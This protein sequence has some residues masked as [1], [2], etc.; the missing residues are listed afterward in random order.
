[1]PSN[2]RDSDTAHG[3]RCVRRC[4]H[5]DGA[6]DAEAAVPARPNQRGHGTLQTLGTRRLTLARVG[7]IGHGS[8]YTRQRRRCR[9]LLV[10]FHHHSILAHRLLELLVR[11]HKLACQKRPSIRRR[12]LWWWWR[13]RHV[14]I[15]GC[16]PARQLH[17][18]V[19]IAKPPSFVINASHSAH[20]H[21]NESA[22][23]FLKV[24]RFCFN[25]R[26]EVVWVDRSYR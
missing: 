16:R 26:T 7:F 23:F 4:A 1:M 2:M 18:F 22:L 8:W 12:R 13:Q 10:L 9:R 20:V 3:A 25:Q 11:A 14:S 24:E 15:C 21:A 19:E 6:S 17:V 5:L